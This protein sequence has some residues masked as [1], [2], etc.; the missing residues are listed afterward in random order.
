MLQDHRWHMTNSNIWY[1][2]VA[3]IQNFGFSLAWVFC[4]CKV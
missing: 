4:I 1:Y 2:T 3:K